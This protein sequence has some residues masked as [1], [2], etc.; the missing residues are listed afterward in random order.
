MSEF[1]HPNP[2][3]WGYI[4]DAESI[5]DIITA[6]EFANFTN[7][8]FGSDVRIV[9]NIASASAAIRNY[10]GWH[11]SPSL[12]CAMTYNVRDLR[13][14]FVGRDLLIQLP[15]TFATEINEVS[16]DGDIVDA[17]NIDF[18][19]GSGLVRVFDVGALD[20]KSKLYIEY[21]AGF[22]DTAVPVVKE[23]C[24]ACVTHALT[25]TYGINSEAAGGVSV[26]YNTAL[27]A[28]GSTSLST[29]ARA[30]LDPYKVRG[31][32]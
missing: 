23:I 31:V 4:V 19:I 25:N 8:K 24:A 5:P 10:C 1:L 11:I 6:V 16:I 27:T 12:R 26:S 2:T 20:R 9:P 28:S 7:N 15:A 14:A 29:N 13:D 30:I 32:F 18:N 21:A 3:P 22:V 17:E